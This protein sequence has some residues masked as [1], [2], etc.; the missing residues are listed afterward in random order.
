MKRLTAELPTLTAPMKDKELMVYLS[1]AYEAVSAVLLVERKVRHMPIHYVSRS[2]QGVEVIMD[3]PINQILNSLKASGRLAKCAIELGAYGISYALRNIIKGQVL[4]DFLANTVASDDPTC[5]NAP[6]IETTLALEDVQ[7]SSKVRKE[8]TE[9]DPAAKENFGREDLYP[10][11]I[12]DLTA[13]G[14]GLH[15]ADS[16]TEGKIIICFPFTMNAKDTIHVQ[17]CELT[18]EE[19]VHFLE[20]YPIPSE[21]SVMLPK[22][23]QTIFDA[24]YGYVGLYTHCF[25]LAN[26]RLP[27]TQFFCDVLQYFHIHISRLNPFGY[28]KLTTF[29]VMCKAYRH[30]TNIRV[31]LDPILFM[32]GLKPSW[33]HEMAFR[34]FMYDETNEDIYFLP[35]EPYPDFG[36]G[37]PSVSINTEPPISDAEPVV[38]LV[39][40]MADLGTLRSTSS[41]VIRAKT[42]SSKDASTLLT[43]S[44]D[45]E[46]LPNV[47]E[48]QDANSCHLKISAITPPAWK[49]HLDNHLD[50]ELLDLHDQCYVRQAVMYNAVNKRSWELLKVIEQIR[51]GCDLMKER[52]RARNEECDG[53]KAK[54]EATMTDFDNNPAMVALYKNIYPFSSEIKEHKANLDRMMLESKKWAGYQV[55][56]STLESKVASLEAEKARLEAVKASPPSLG[57]LVGKIVSPVVFYGRCAAFEE[58]VEMKEPFNL[59]KI[60]QHRSKLFSRRSHQH[61]NALSRTQAPVP[62]S[63]KATPSSAPLS[64]PMSPPAA[65]SSVKVQSPP[66]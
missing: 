54:C 46:G 7:D 35:K 44:D 19:F 31:F 9:P 60:I 41:H 58:V 14:V 39:E 61:F 47:L 57:R 52:E 33:E 59:T 34:N 1:T 16:L 56:L 27:L 23:N 51:G 3:K 40:N 66:V 25:S 24:P 2:L 6:S 38:Q 37:S 12:E 11:F 64:K 55:S 26:L 63:Q 15:V 45:D 50:V 30:L 18:K 21:Y 43:I 22:H 17:T 5:E 10:S 49:N 36:T 62:S 65:V 42:I 48:L 20:L 29:I 8:Q 13:K 32:V 28:A 4:A 53:L